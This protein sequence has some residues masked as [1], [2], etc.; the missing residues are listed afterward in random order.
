LA[1]GTG[2]ALHLGHRFSN[3][4]DMF[5]EKGFDVF[6]LDDYLHGKY[7][8]NTDFSAP[9]TL[10][11]YIGKIKTDFITHPYR[12]IEKLSVEENIRIYSLPDIA[13][14]KLNA[15][16][17]SGTR[18]RDFIDLYFLLQHYSIEQLIKFYESKYASKNV[19]H[20]IKS[21]NYFE[22]VDLSDWPMLIKEKDI[23]WY[24]VKNVIDKRC[25]SFIKKIR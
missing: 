9:N 11:G 25:K 18:S 15:I 21:L 24:K 17:G 22:D 13:A 23:D 20:V 7:D 16:A 5:S 12:R 2:L 1:G 4:L 8:F 14:M 19:L 10:K 3:D 6:F